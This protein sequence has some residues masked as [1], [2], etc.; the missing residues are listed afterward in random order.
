MGGQP[1]YAQGFG[2]VPGG[3]VHGEY[4]NLDS[5]RDLVDDDTC[6]VVVEPMQ[7]EGGVLPGD[8]EFLRGLRALCDAHDALLIFDEV[9]TGVGRTGTLYAYQQL[10]VTPDILTSAKALGGGF[11]VGAMLTTDRVASAFAFGTHGSTYGGNPLASAVALAAVEFI[12]TPEVLEGVK[13]RHALFREHLEAINAKHG[14]FG[15]IRG[16]GLLI[17]AVMSPDY[18][19]RAAEIL[20]LAIEEGLMALVAGPNVLRMA[21]SLVIPEADIAEGMARLE[22]AVARLVGER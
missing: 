18:E 22:R 10:G 2:P 11:P 8:I 4:N 19:G 5:V 3:I 20:P 17:G 6:A 9:Q 15:E 21:P 1:K 7:G 14:V 13:R 16:M 12:D